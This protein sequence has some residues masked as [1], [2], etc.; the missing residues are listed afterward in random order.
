M[1]QRHK[2]PIQILKFTSSRKEIHERVRVNLNLI[3]QVELIIFE[4]NTS[5][6]N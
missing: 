6:T 4:S 1:R 2:K 3:L 5:K